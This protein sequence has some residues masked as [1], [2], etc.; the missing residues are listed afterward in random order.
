MNAKI[1]NAIG[2]IMLIAFVSD[3]L[4]I[5]VNMS[6]NNAIKNMTPA[7]TIIPRNAI[8]FRSDSCLDNWLDMYTRNP[9][10][11]GST[12]T[13]VSGVSIPK[14]NASNISDND[15]IITLTPFIYFRL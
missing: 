11:S 8:F 3:V 13:A 6:P 10:Y 7:D 5:V 4:R 9:G 2:D 14:I 12:Q 15:S 1:L